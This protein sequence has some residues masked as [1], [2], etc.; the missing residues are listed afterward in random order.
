MTDFPVQT[1]ITLIICVA[2]V[3]V[4]FL[5]Y[6]HSER[7]EREKEITNRIAATNGVDMKRFR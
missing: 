6:E 5:S 4:C 2:V 3:V 7:V 1:Q